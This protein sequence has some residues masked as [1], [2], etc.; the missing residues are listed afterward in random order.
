[1]DGSSSMV[2]TASAANTTVSQA[3]MSTSLVETVAFS[4]G[5]ALD[6]KVVGKLVITNKLG[7]NGASSSESE[8]E[9]HGHAPEPG[10]GNLPHNQSGA[11]QPSRGSEPYP[12]LHAQSGTRG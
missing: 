1:M 4:F 12:L 2:G 11:L 6:E 9:D 10:M 7:S 8:T 3:T 5:S